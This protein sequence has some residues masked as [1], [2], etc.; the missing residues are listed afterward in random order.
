LA[1]GTL[2]APKVL[3]NGN[4]PSVL[5]GQTIISFTSGEI[6]NYLANALLD[7]VFNNSAYTAPGTTWV[8]LATASIADATTGATIG[9]PSG[10]AYARAQ[11]NRNGGASP[12]WDLSASSV[13]DNGGTINFATATA[14]W[15]TVTG[16][17][18]LDAS[19]TGN[20]L[21]YDNTQ[22]DQAVGSG[23]LWRYNAGDLDVVCS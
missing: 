17:A 15:G 4:S 11:I 12:T 21:F 23:D 2:T 8:G 6:S 3:Y 10:G 5:S 7:H 13:V 16:V 9:E 1:H 22:T 18:I 14:S 19:T 20:L